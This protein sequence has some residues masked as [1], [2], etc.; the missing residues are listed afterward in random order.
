MLDRVRET[1]HGK[2]TRATGHGGNEGRSSVP[3]A[4]TSMKETKK[5]VFLK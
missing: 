5:R 2:A 4:G 3:R 1:G